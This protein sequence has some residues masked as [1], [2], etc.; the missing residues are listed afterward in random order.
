MENLGDK[1]IE[2]FV[3]AGLIKSFADIF[4]LDKAQLLELPRQGEKSVNNLLESIELAKKTTLDRLIYGLG[5]RF[6]GEQ[7][8]KLLAAR[9]GTLEKFIN[10]TEEE[11]LAVDEIGPKVA[12]S[13]I[14]ALSQKA[15]KKGLDQLLHSGLI[16]EKRVKKA[17]SEKLAGQ[18]F[19]ITGTL[20]QARDAVKAII[21]ENGGV[22]QNSVSKKTKVLLAGEEAGSKL[23]KAQE[24]GVAIWSWEDFQKQIG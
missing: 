14:N 15:F 2:Q 11:L 7:T 4:T 8:A 18:T 23:D 10:A 17:A 1:Q 12:Q 22:V 24:L 13:I 3:E 9:F 16:L 19:V 21:E 20:P 5:I 6:V